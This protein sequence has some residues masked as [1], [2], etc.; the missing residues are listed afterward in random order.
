MGD[1]QSLFCSYLV[2]RIWKDYLTQH[3]KLYPEKN[4]DIDSFLDNIDPIH[5][6][7]M[8]LKYF[9]SFFPSLFAFCTDLSQIRPGAIIKTNFDGAPRWG[10][11]VMVMKNNKTH[12]EVITMTQDGTCTEQDWHWGETNGPLRIYI[13]NPLIPID[14][15]HLMTIITK[16][17]R[18]LWKYD[19]RAA[20]LSAFYP[21]YKKNT[22][23]QYLKQTMFRTIRSKSL[24]FKTIDRSCM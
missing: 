1:H 18:S 21:C 17:K 24:T 20:V 15:K 3:G 14:I 7:P 6:T 8:D 23:L 2:I 11:A 22:G 9:V 5:C 16:L 4:K 19:I 12:I 10:H 13:I